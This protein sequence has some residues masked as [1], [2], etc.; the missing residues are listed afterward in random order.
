M[1]TPGVVEGA[2]ALRAGLGDVRR[3]ATGLRAEEF[4]REPGEAHRKR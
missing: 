4:L 3:T 2:A 1:R